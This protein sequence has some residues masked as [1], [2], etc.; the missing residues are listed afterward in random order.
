MTRLSAVTEEKKEKKEN[1]T[2]APKAF[3]YC[4]VTITGIPRTLAL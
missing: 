1:P 2:V 4:S 3:G